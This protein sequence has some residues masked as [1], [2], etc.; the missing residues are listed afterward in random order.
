MAAA[1]GANE[2]SLLSRGRKTFVRDA[3]DSGS[4]GGGQLCE[5]SG[6]SGSVSSPAGGCDVSGG[7]SGELVHVVGAG[8][9]VCGQPTGRADVENGATERR[10]D[11]RGKRRSEIVRVDDGKRRGLDREADRCVSGKDG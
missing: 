5:R 2:E 9:E 4:R 3:E 10:C 11:R 6:A 8:P 1:R 7:P